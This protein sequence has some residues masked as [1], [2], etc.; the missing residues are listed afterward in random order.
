MRKGIILFLL[1]FLF[2]TKPFYIN[3]QEFRSD[4]HVEYFLKELPSQLIS[5]VRFNIKITHLKSDV[6]VKKYSLTFPK[7]FT[8]KDITASD[9][10]GPI[11]PIT[12]LDDQ[13]TSVEMEFTDPQ[14][15]KD[16]SNNLFLNFTQENLFKV[17]GNVWEVILPTV[18]N[19]QDGDYT[20]IVN[21]PE[22]TNK[23]ISIAK[24][25]PDSISGQQ[26]IWHNPQTKTV[27]AVF[28]DKQYYKTKL[29]YNL[30]NP[31]LIPVYTDIALP[32]DSLYQKIFIDNLTPPP[33]KVYIDDDGNYLARYNLNPKE[34]K[35]VLFEGV[36][37]IFSAAR[38]ELRDLMITQINNQSKYLLTEK[39]YW[40][41]TTPEKFNN[42][43]SAQDIYYY[44][45]NNLRYDYSKL[46]I[47]EGRVGA[48]KAVLK[49]NKAV[50]TEFTDLFI[51]LAREK[52]IYSREIEGYGFSADP[53]LRPMS[54]VTDVLHAWPE[55]YDSVRKLWVSVDPTWENTSGI[56][57]FS[58]FD[59]NH[60]VFVIHGKD[61]IYPYPAG[62]YKT[63]DSK[64]IIINPISQVPS[65]I[66]KLQF[67]PIDLKKIVY[68][69][70]DYLT[71]I[72]I[73]N[74]GNV[75]KY[76]QK[77]YIKASYLSFNPSSIIIDQ[78]A[79]WQE[80]EITINF[81]S[82]KIAGKKNTQLVILSEQGQTLF[83]Q[84]ITIFPFYY[85]IAINY[86]FIGLFLL[87]AII[88]FKYVKRPA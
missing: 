13:Q 49:P 29:I 33:N 87:L 65:E 22:K 7:F 47:G 88:I 64:D 35:S 44:V 25:K 45:T 16:S 37:G 8:I 42:L 80:K 51:G 27:Y 82:N 2:L 39:D 20:I 11:I 24:P 54:F 57:Y 4:F 84:P 36:I 52:G 1:L 38:P 46:N 32:P 34:T 55:Y 12:K 74:R 76:N 83:Q 60:I 73:I 18:E 9:D 78:I 67:V 58:S 77:F 53:Q 50:C 23:K 56:D 81:S 41:I 26:L 43:K 63:E 70:K 66:N 71:K 40:K 69:K 21:L 3:A 72:K 85:D 14:T 28:G 59:L 30:N 48:S 68:Q 61:T 5:N 17:N 6:Y 10:K 79:P 75:F 31:K 86:G 19:R 15:G 62:M